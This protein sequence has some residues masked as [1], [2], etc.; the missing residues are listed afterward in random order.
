MESERKILILVVDDNPNNLKVIGNILVDSGYNIIA[1]T[2]GAKAILAAQSKKPDLILLDI[3]MP[4]IDGYE[5]CKQLKAD[6]ATMHIPVVFLSAKDSIDDLVQGF[7]L[8]GVDYITKPF[9]NE[10]VLV[11]IKNHA[12]LALAKKQIEEKNEELAAALAAKNK[13]FSIIA[14]DLRNPL[15]SFLMITEILRTQKKTLSEV[16]YD[17]FLKLMN[18]SA[19]NLQKLLENL[20]AWAKSQSGAMKYSPSDYDFSALVD[21]VN[22]SFSA[23]LSQK[24]ITFNSHIPENTIVYIDYEMCSVILRN[25]IS[26]AIKF[27]PKGG[28]IELS[29]KELTT[30]YE[31]CVSD[32]G[33]GINAAEIHK[34]FDIQ[35]KFSHPG[36]EKEAGSGLGL[37]LCKAFIEQNN[38]TIRVESHEGDGSKFYFTLTK[39]KL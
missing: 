5:V 4:E 35:T 6:E 22:H 12:E 36:T 8:G 30:H 3:M 38:G 11:R 25:L 20:L 24:S 32:S 17:N 27:T 34:L 23:Q 15:S 21:E 18:N 10:E 29:C 7:R 26:N 2:S 37:I 31:F 39:S 19:T 9:N 16:E 1:V 33:V 13:F 14:H 28:T